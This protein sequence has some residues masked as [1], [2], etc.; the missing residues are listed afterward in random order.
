MVPRAKRLLLKILD[1]SKYLVEDGDVWL[2]PESEAKLRRRIERELNGIMVEDVLTNKEVS[3]G[4]MG[5]GEIGKLDMDGEIKLKNVLG[6]NGTEG[7][8]TRV[9]YS[10]KMKVGSRQG[11]VPEGKGGARG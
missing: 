4:T 6:K 11:Y 8:Q 3:S 1:S 9:L 7:R 5:M 10:S 2:Q